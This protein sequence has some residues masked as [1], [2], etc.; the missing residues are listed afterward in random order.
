MG[1]LDSS[2][3]PALSPVFIPGNAAASDAAKRA[4]HY[5]VAAKIAPR[6]T[7]SIGPLSWAV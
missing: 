2:V 7:C 4:A 5:A 3:L 6:A 1:E